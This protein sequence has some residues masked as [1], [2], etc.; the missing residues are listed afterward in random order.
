MEQWVEDKMFENDRCREEENRKRNKIIMDRIDESKRRIDRWGKRVEEVI[1]VIRREVR[2]TREMI[3]GVR[4][5]E[6]REGDRGEEEKMKKEQ[7]N[8]G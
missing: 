7:G 1:E 4:E 6:E 8:I 2:E 3:I 5:E